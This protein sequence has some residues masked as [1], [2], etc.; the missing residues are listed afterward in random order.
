MPAQAGIFVLGRPVSVIVSA[1]MFAGQL[2]RFI[3]RL[4][5]GLLAVVVAVGVLALLGTFIPYPLGAASAANGERRILVV[6]NPIHTDIA[7]PVDADTLARFDFLAPA[8]LP[9][10]HPDARWL[11]VGWGGRSFYL[12][13]PTF[14]DI[15]L[16]PTL[17]ALTLDR[18]V[19]HVDVV[20]TIVQGHPQVQELAI[21]EQD[22]ARLL[23]AML[24][25]FT[26]EDGAVVP[27]DGYAQGASDRFFE[28]EGTFNALL[29]CNTWTAR[30]LREA[31][32]RTG[33]W[34]PLPVSLSTS[35][36]LF[37]PQRLV[38]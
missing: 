16:E 11:L 24:A 2:M 22:Y 38:R 8:G 19:R 17:R 4:T 37:N 35:L 26:R 15:K 10:A 28:A 1:Y 9:V 14:A 12:E 20:T 33:L 36:A 32:L 34:N 5:I 29:G 13:T 25:S 3:L 30:M 27:I 31:G 21:S 7:I 18:S 6:S 23:D